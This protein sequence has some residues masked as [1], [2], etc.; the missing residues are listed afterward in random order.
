MTPL[1]AN[2]AS[3]QVSFYT[4]PW[5]ATDTVVGGS[6][7]TGTVPDATAPGSR[8]S[9]PCRPQGKIICEPA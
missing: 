9:K 8:C 6:C 1:Y 4:T 2:T 7:P 5:D 3:R